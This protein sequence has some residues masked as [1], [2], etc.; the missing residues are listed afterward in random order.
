LNLKNEFY[1]RFTGP[2]F[3]FPFIGIF[4]L[5]LYLLVTSSMRAGVSFNSLYW[6]FPFESIPLHEIVWSK[7]IH[8]QFPL[9]GFS[10]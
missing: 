2:Y 10:L 3:Q 4:P 8:F 9:L 1:R 5:N 6:D 7:H